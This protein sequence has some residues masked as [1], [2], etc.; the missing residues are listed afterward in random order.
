MSDLKI[1]IITVVYNGE[2]YLEQTIQ[3]ILSQTYDNIEYII[4]DGGS[5]DGTLDIIKKNEDKISHWVSERDEG[6]T[7]ALIK[8]FDLAHGDVLYW[9]NYDDLLFDDNTVQTV[10]DKFV[11]KDVDL[12]YGNDMLV[13][14]NLNIIKIRDFSFHSFAKLL[15]YKS[16][17]QP[18]AFFSKRMYKK[19]G[20]NRDLDYSMDLDLW[21]NIF[22]KNK[23]VYLNKILAKNRIH[24]E[25][26]ML[27]FKEDAER[28][29][30]K[31]RLQHGA[32]KK[33][34]SFFRFIFQVLEIKNYFWAKIV[35]L[36]Y[37]K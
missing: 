5:T 24:D 9:L 27:K 21:L 15:Y 31:L 4:I 34:F 8:G 37:D 29:A 32:N 10:V 28:E 13:D 33:Y 7:D 1:S 25:R 14:K 6:Q 11:K 12:V 30:K 16:I 36:Y 2:K 19:F 17:S 20:L 26:K 22:K 3:S 35:R 23:V 18:A